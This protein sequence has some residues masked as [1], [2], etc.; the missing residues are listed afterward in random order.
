MHTSVGKFYLF[1]ED[2]AI[3]LL[4]LIVL[5]FIVFVL[6]GFG[7]SFFTGWFSQTTFKNAGLCAAFV[8]SVLLILSTHDKIR[9][10]ILFVGAFPL[11]LYLM[12]AEETVEGSLDQRAL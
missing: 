11:C 10:D 12:S 8:G 2:L 1:L 7:A 3:Y 5:G 9:E 6:F 4:G